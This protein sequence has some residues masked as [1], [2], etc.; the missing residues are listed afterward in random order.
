MAKKKEE[1]PLTKASKG[2]RVEFTSVACGTLSKSLCPC[3]DKKSEVLHNVRLLARRLAIASKRAAHALDVAMRLAA[4]NPGP[5]G[6]M[7]CDDFSIRRIILHLL[8]FVFGGPCAPKQDTRWDEASQAARSNEV[9]RRGYE[10]WQSSTRVTA[11]SRTE[12]FKGVKPFTLAILTPL[13]NSMEAAVVG[14]NRALPSHVAATVRAIL[15]SNKC[16]MA[17]RIMGIGKK[18]LRQAAMT[19]KAVEKAKERETWM[20]KQEAVDTLH[21]VIDK[22]VQR[23]CQTNSKP[24]NRVPS[25]AGARGTI[26]FV[27]HDA[28]MLCCGIVFVYSSTHIRCCMRAVQQTPAS[29]SW[30]RWCGFWQCDEPKPQRWLLHFR[31]TRAAC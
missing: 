26:Q 13:A 30:P 17:R 29:T 10:A 28:H 15:G 20:E 18:L 19:A 11:L 3:D 7:I 9:A 12:G 8:K 5:S 14:Y 4:R 1:K 22:E 2:T 25:L 31:H 16:S 24:L 23:L 6:R 21:A 27:V